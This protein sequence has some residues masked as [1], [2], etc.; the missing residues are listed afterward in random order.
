MYAYVCMYVGKYALEYIN[1]VINY[2]RNIHIYIY[3]CVYI[4]IHTY[5]HTYISLSIYIYIERESIYIYIC[6]YIYICICCSPHLGNGG[7]PA[8]LAEAR[9]LGYKAPCPY[10]A[11]QTFQNP[12]IQ[13]YTLNHCRIHN[14]ILGIFLD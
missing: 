1:I 14:M 8:R 10:I 6:V 11:T 9:R 4:Y 13:E 2:K 12:L 7:A 5:I 3:I